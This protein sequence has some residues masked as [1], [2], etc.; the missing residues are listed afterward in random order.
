MEN[1]FSV[2]QIQAGYCMSYIL[3]SDKQAVIIDPHITKVQAYRDH[4]KAENLTLKAV[5]DTHTHADHLSSAG[6]VSSE[7]GCPVFMSANAVSSMGIRKVSAGDT[8]SFG[9]AALAVT[10]APGHTDDSIAL[11]GGGAVFTGDVLLIG[12]V[13]RTDF[14]NGSPEDMF[15]T[16]ARLKELPDETAVYPAHDYNDQTSSTIGRQKE[17]NPYMI[18]TDRDAFCA[19]ARSKTLDK[20][21]NMDAIIRANREGSAREIEH[22]SVSEAR[23]RLDSPDESWTILDVRRPEEYQAL[24]IEQSQNIPLD[25]L[26]SRLNEVVGSDQQ[27]ILSCLSGARASMAAGILAAAGAGRVTVMT[28]A[29]KAWI[30]ENAPV[31]REKVPV[32]LERQV[33]AIAGSLVLLGSLL[34]LLVS[35][36]F[37]AIPIFVGSGLLFAGVSNTCMMGMLLMKV[38]YNRK[39][40][41][42]NAPVGG[43][44]SLDGGGGGRC[45]M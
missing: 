16:L 40:L 10:P 28:G 13:G 5:I 14:Q 37:F 44:C 41:Q 23:R 43:T 27:L 38:P 26:S 31:I 33:R 34:G 22:I 15:D 3:E 42:R 21:F 18:E 11:T 25:S 45:A 1:A 24:R 12:A 39:A 6:I 36:W 7:Y 8:I 4:I 30:K 9:Q 19:N 32:S 2:K 35:A 29:I 17:N 20:P